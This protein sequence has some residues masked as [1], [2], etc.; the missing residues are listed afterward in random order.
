MKHFLLGLAFLAIAC[1]G[2]SSSDP[3]SGVNGNDCEQGGKSASNRYLPTTVGDVWRYD[4]TDPTGVDPQTIKRQEITEE[5]VPDGETEPVFVQET[6]KNTGRTV[7]WMRVVGEST[8]RVQQQD[9][10]VNGVLERTTRYEPYRLRLDESAE[11]LAQGATW[12]ETYTEI[13]YDPNGV[14]LQR[15]DAIDQ[16]TIMAVDMPCAT[17][18][19]E[20]SCIHV[21][22]EQIQGGIAIKDYFFARGYGK[23]RE[24]GGQI[25][26]LKGCILN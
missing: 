13:V 20:L 17:P 4:V 3:D 9:Y 24:E 19:G 18:W 22:R 8:V 21:H 14:E 7:N 15:I 6:T 2:G 11:R 26:T 12:D 1:G 23:I 5:F 16:W 25:E 10:D